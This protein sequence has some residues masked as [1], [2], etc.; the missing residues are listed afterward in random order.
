MAGHRCGESQFHKLEVWDEGVE[1]EE[2]EAAGASEMKGEELDENREGN[3][4]YI[5]LNAMSTMAVP[6]FRTIRVTGHVGKQLIN[7]FIDCGSSH[8]FI[9]PSVVQKLGLKTHKV[10]PVVV[11]VTDG[12]KLTTSELC[13]IF[14]WKMQGQE[15]KADLLVL[16]VGGCE[17]VLGIQWLATLG[18]VKWNFGEL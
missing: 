7:V 3:L 1:E 13:S 4:A 10:N 2:D 12:N 9:H 14:T 6:T 18:D 11:E 8:N 16:P 15:F 5:S 17:V